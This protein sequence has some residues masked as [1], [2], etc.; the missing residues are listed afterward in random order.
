MIKDDKEDED[1]KTKHTL[2]KDNPKKDFNLK[3]KKW[4]SC[5]YSKNKRIK[6]AKKECKQY[7]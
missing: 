2:Y 3:S 7:L 4:V 6:A 5:T 1:G